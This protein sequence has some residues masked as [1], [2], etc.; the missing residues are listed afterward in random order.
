MR[1][2]SA[3]MLV[4]MLVACSNAQDLRAVPAMRAAQQRTVSDGTSGY[5]YAT[6]FSFQGF[7]GA[8]PDGVLVYFKGKLYGTTMAGGYYSAGTVF[9]VTPSGEETVL[10]SFGQSGDGVEPEAGL[11]VLDGVLYGTT[12]SGGTYNHGI[13]FSITPSGRERVLY[14]FGYQ[15]GDGANLVAGLTPLNGVLYGTTPYGGAGNAGTAFEITTAGKEKVIYYFPDYSKKD[16]ENP[17]AGLLAYKGKF[18]GTTV[19]WGPCGEGTVYSLTPTGRVHTIYGFP[20]RRYD[21]SNPQ[22][23]LAVVN[24]VLYGTTTYGGKAFYNDGTVFSVTLSG[25]EKVLFNFVPPSEYGAGPNTALVL[26]KGV[27]YGTTPSEAAN[28]DGAVYSITPSGQAAVLHSFGIPPDGAT[29]LAGL[30]NV[31]GTL[32]GTTSAGGGVGN[33]GTIF[34]VTP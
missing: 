24:G 27:L 10:H 5:Q 30:A 9:S 31:N 17:F 22:G 15:A 34:R 8:I 11:T 6:I 26:Q 2:L 16:G 25:K 12:Y 1:P 19:T 20:C 3:G 13:V 14:S 23:A 18:Y 21:G 4:W 33:A 32:Y 29:P 28:G 7:N